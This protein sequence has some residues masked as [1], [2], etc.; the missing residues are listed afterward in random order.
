VAPLSADGSEFAFTVP[1]GLRVEH[2]NGGLLDEIDIR[3]E[4]GLPS[5]RQDRPQR[6]RTA[7]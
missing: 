7:S 5:D 1:Q 4:C 3:K 2:T 6:R